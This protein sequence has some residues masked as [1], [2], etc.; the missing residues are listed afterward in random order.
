MNTLL[1]ILWNLHIILESLPISSSSHLQLLT[2]YLA[3]RHK[4]L[5]PKI[6]STTEYLMHIP[7]ALVLG[8]TLFYHKSAFQTQSFFGLAVAAC[9]ADG[10]TGC[11]YLLMK[12]FGKPRLPFTFGFFISSCALLSLYFAPYGT[13][14]HISISQAFLIGLAQA[15]TLLP[16]IWR[17]AI[18]VVMPIWLGID[19]LI[20]V[21]FSLAIELGSRSRIFKNT[22]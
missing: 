4:T 20:A 14:Q 6:S 3:N 9:I 10:V 5:S 8:M 2:L 18:T 13:S 7:T 11:T 16:G 17:L 12:K 22:I 21:L 15:T 1:F 19:P